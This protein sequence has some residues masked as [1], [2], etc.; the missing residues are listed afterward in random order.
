MNL[1][2]C[3]EFSCQR[4][5]RF[6]SECI[7]NK[8]PHIKL[9][10]TETRHGC[11]KCNQW[12]QLCQIPFKLKKAFSCWLTFEKYLQV[13]NKVYSFICGLC[14]ADIKV[15]ILFCCLFTSQGSVCEGSNV[16]SRQTQKTKFTARVEKHF[17]LY[18][19]IAKF[20]FRHQI[21]DKIYKK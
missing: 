20:L 4:G 9:Q 19:F 10:P 8:L 11:L 18:M 5:T 2:A 15:F 6:S 16:V 12:V 14:A 3:Y 17:F 13:W 7:F 1:T 21:V